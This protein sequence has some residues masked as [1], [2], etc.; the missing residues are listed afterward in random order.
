MLHLLGVSMVQWLVCCVATVV[1]SQVSGCMHP[2]APLRLFCIAVAK[3]QV[4]REL[5]PDCCKVVHQLYAHGCQRCLGDS[6]CMCVRVFAVPMMD[7]YKVFG[8]AVADHSGLSGCVCCAEGLLCC[9]A[10]AAVRTPAYAFC[11]AGH[12]ANCSCMIRS[13]IRPCQQ[14][15]A[16]NNASSFATAVWLLSQQLCCRAGMGLTAV[17]RSRVGWMHWLLR[18]QEA[19][20]FVG[21]CSVW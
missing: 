2:L 9:G 13:D 16:L 14:C 15:G 4:R 5:L 7:R 19:A 3:L 11:S 12:A 6:T 1:H 8:V 18:F 20:L 21:S 17:D 10:H